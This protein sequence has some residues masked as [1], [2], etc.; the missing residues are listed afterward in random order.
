MRRRICRPNAAKLLA[1]QEERK[2]QHKEVGALCL[3]TTVCY[4]HLLLEQSY[5]YTIAIS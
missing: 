2:K 3:L 5:S 4:A 1:F